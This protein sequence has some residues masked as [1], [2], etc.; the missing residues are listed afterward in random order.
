AT[1]QDLMKLTEEMVARVA[2]EVT[3]NDEVPYQ[4]T[5]IKWA[6]PWPRISMLGE[7]AKLLVPEVASGESAQLDALDRLPAEAWL[8]RAGDD[9]EARHKFGR[10]HSTGAKIAWALEAF[11]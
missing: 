2:V 4:G 1:Y 10:A 9:K 8:A 11:C 7:V 6:P 5:V 3:R